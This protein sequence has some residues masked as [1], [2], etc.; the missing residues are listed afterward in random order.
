LSNGLRRVV[1][2]LC[3]RSLFTVHAGGV[4]RGVAFLSLS[5]LGRLD[6]TPL[7]PPRA[8]EPCNTGGNTVH[9]VHIFHRDYDRHK[10]LECGTYRISS[11]LRSTVAR[12]CRYVLY[13]W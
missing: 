8:S 6:A 5:L 1:V 12:V 2:W 9:G 7:L 3:S 10:P 13:V 4:R 11:G